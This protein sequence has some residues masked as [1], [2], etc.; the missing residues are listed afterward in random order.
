VVRFPVEAI[1]KRFVILGHFRHLA[2]V[3]KTTSQI[4]RYRNNAEL[5]RGVVFYRAG[6]CSCFDMD[7]VVQPDNQFA[8]PHD[9]LES[10]HRRGNLQ[11][12]GLLPHGFKDALIVAID[13]SDTLS[14]VERNRLL[15]ILG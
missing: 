14:E 9:F 12:L 15:S 11:I 5:M 4:E 10:T 8:V 13:R 7:T 6:A 3:L 1:P 2:L